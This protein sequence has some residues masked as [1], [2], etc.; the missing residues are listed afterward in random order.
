[1]AIGNTLILMLV[2]GTLC[3]VNVLGDFGF[4]E[5]AEEDVSKQNAE[6]RLHRLSLI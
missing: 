2:F 3:A 4:P 1:M 6:V 5:A